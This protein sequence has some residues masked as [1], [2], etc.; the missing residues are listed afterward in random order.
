MKKYTLY[1]EYGK[2]EK[3]YNN[4]RNVTLVRS[5]FDTGQIKD[6]LC[7]YEYFTIQEVYDI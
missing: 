1:S 6:L 5:S 2:Y 3:F 4:S 7:T